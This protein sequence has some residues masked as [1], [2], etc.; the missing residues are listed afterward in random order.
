[1]QLQ[2]AMAVSVLAEL[3]VTAVSHSAVTAEQA[4]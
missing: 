4:E 1:M 3:A 2:A